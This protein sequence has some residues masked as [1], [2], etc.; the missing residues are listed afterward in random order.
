M[1]LQKAEAVFEKF[2]AFK[3]AKNVYLLMCISSWSN[4]F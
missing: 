3:L 4:P 2:Q 1:K